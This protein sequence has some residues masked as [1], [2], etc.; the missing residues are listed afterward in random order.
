MN[1]EIKMNKSKIEEKKQ[2]ILKKNLSLDKEGDNLLM[3]QIRIDSFFTSKEIETF[4]NEFS[5]H[6]DRIKLIKYKI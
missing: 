6:K 3:E 4:F 1:C 5:S 2:E